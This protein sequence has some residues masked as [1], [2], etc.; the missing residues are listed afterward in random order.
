MDLSTIIENLTNGQ[1]IKNALIEL[2]NKLKNNELSEEDKML[3]LVD[4]DMLFM[5]LSEDDPKSRRAAA[6]ILS[7]LSVDGAMEEIFEAYKEE[8][9][10]YI[11]ADLLEALASF[12]ISEIREELLLRQKELWD[13]KPEE[14]EKKHLAE[15]LMALSKLLRTEEEDQ[16]AVF[17]DNSDEE[18]LLT[19]K[20][21]LQDV[22]LRQIHGLPKKKVP[23]GVMVKSPTIS[24]LMNI[25]TFQ[26]ALIF[27]CDLDESSDAALIG[28]AIV[29]GGLINVIDRH[30]SGRV[31]LNFR[32]SILKGMDSDL[33]NR[34]THGI[35][36]EIFMKAGGRL[37]NNPSDYSLEIRLYGRKEEGFKVFLKFSDLNDNRFAYRQ[38]VTSNTMKPYMA[39]TLVELARPHLAEKAQVLDPFCGVGTLLVE[40]KMALYTG[41]VYG[42][43]RFAEAIDKARKNCSEFSTG[44]HF[45]NRDIES[46][47]HD[48]AFDEIFTDMPISSNKVSREEIIFDYETLF[49]KA[50][51]LLKDGGKLIVY[52]NEPGVVRRILRN[53]KEFLLLTDYV[54]DSKLDYHMFAISMTGQAR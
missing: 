21:G 49:D 30:Y 38:E 31:N 20:A 45:I 24:R 54:I 19:T 44:M 2:K 6:Q 37:I 53:R 7:I 46:F 5:F 40:R 1:G 39:A 51:I 35:C 4:Q 32:L 26:D 16:K 42:V 12:D 41:D 22:T 3:L 52:G 18:I 47:S 50:S 13:Y 34:L 43:D 10:L 28:D 11:K 27:L 23:Q 14:S 8:E 29:S 33:K 36:K 9:T 15:E 48:Y 25:R 17:I